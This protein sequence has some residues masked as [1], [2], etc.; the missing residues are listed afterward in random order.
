M[1]SESSPPWISRRLSAP[2][3]PP[4]ATP[5]DCYSS[6]A[7]SRDPQTSSFYGIHQAEPT[8]LMTHI[9]KHTS[10]FGICYDPVVKDYKVVIGDAKHY[11]VFHCRTNSWS[12]TKETNVFF[13]NKLT[14]EEFDVV[15][16]CNGVSFKGSVYWLL[17]TTAG[18]GDHCEIVRFD[19]RDEELKKPWEVDIPG[20]PNGHLISSREGL[21]L[22]P[23]YSFKPET[24][25]VDDN[26]LILKKVDDDTWTEIKVQL[27]LSLGSVIP[28]CWTRHNQILFR[29]CWDK[30]H[31]LYDD[32]NGSFALVKNTLDLR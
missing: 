20:I 12:K 9:D 19:G 30:K 10:K 14:R 17:Y 16:F 28:L 18:E 11:A 4:F 15:R 22:F 29:V 1:D 13:C 31:L 8:E 21:Y 7:N 6:G 2:R 27:P 24:E 25:R 23:Y 26:I 3:A 5:T 32:T